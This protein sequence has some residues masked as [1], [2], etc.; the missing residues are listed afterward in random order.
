MAIPVFPRMITRLPCWGSIRKF[1]FQIPKRCGNKE[2]TTF[3]SQV[4]TG[5]LKTINTWEKVR[6]AF[7]GTLASSTE[8]TIDFLCAELERRT[9]SPRSIVD[10]AHESIGNGNQSEN[11]R[12]AKY[13][14]TASWRDQINER[15]RQTGENSPGAE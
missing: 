15:A 13:P 4:S 5:Q 8:E 14:C 10:C 7:H 6:D 11:T 1:V 3:L 12:L 9:F 2:W